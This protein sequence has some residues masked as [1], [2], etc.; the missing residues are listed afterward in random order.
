MLAMFLC[1]SSSDKS[2]SVRLCSSYS[3]IWA[4]LALIC[5]TKI[6][7]V[8]YLRYSSDVS[9]SVHCFSG[10]RFFNIKGVH[11]TML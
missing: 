5:Q 9:A 10:L 7:K 6:L 2:V 3:D 1:I 4:F 11:K 8:G